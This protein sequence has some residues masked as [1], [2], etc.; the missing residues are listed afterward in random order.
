MPARRVDIRRCRYWCR[1]SSE[2]DRTSVKAVET[3]WAPDSCSPLRLPPRIIVFRPVVDQLPKLD[4][5]GS[6]PVAR[7]LMN[8]RRRER[9][10]RRLEMKQHEVQ[11]DRLDFI[12]SRRGRGGGTWG[13]HAERVP[14]ARGRVRSALVPRVG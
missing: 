12:R 6:T 9:F 4:V 1:L 2:T 10:P 11:P 13:R 14:G 7:S 3:G 8:V 5:A